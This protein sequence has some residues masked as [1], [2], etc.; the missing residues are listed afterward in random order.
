MNTQTFE[1]RHDMLK[2]NRLGLRPRDWV[3]EI[4]FKYKMKS[5]SVWSDWGRRGQW[6]RQILQADDAEGLAFDILYDY[7]QIL[8]DA[9]KMSKVEENPYVKVSALKL[10]LYANLMKQSFLEKL[11]VLYPVFQQFTE[12]NTK[13]DE[14]KFLDKY[15]VY[16]G[17]HGRFLRRMALAM[18]N[19]NE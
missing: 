2:L 16:K 9:K 12:R 4:A 14:D 17:Q 6:M 18:V 15:P 5:G 7:D 10:A 3:E 1:R 13:L 8:I 11:G 19:K